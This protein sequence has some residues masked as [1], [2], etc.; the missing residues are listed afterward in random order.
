MQNMSKP[1]HLE[2]RVILRVDGADAASFLNG[3]LTNTILDL[4]ADQL[5]YG[6]LLTPQGKIICDIILQRTETG[7]LLD[8]PAQADEALL[9]RLKMFKLKADVELRVCDDLAV[10]VF[11]NDGL[12]DPRHP[13][14]P[15][16]LIAETDLYE[17]K[18][19]KAYHV[20]RTKL[21]VAEQG[22]D[23][24][25]NEVFPADINMDLNNGIDFKKGC[26]IGQEVVSRMKRRG[27]ARR[28]TLAFNF[29]NGA[30]Q[31]GTPL[32]VEGT[33]IGEIS[34]STSDFALAKLRIDRLAKAQSAGKTEITA[35]DKKAE[36]IS[37]DWLA[38]Q[39]E[40]VTSS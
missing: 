20:E 6:A 30:P 23:F 7:F 27:T 3:L 22:K 13:E 40:A 17:D 14:M 16:R 10:Y 38:E 34:S 33:V 31:A 21:G 26:F 28:R 18:S 1:I 29:P 36:L 35:N 8:V 9:K 15:R 37:P 12:T 4:S 39:I 32:E 5:G 25:E 19:C 24:G 2:D 11:A